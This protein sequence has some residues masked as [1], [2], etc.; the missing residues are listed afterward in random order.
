M[1][2]RQTN[3]RLAAFNPIGECRQ[4]FNELFP[5]ETPETFHA[6]WKCA[7]FPPTHTRLQQWFGSFYSRYP[8]QCLEFVTFVRRDIGGSRISKFLIQSLDAFVIEPT[9]DV[10]LLPNEVQDKDVARA[11]ER[12]HQCEITAEAVKKERQRLIRRHIQNEK[13]L[14]DLTETC[15]ATASWKGSKVA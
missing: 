14:A 2:R 10:A 13:S 4:K 7:V 11:I 6:I 1:R 12:K 5:G 3:Y 9:P 8:D 15:A